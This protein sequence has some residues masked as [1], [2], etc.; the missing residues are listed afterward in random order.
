M[1]QKISRI[2]ALIVT[3]VLSVIAFFLRSHQLKT[4]FDEVGVIPGSGTWVLTVF[5][6]LAVVVF[7]AYA[8]ILRGR[9]KY[10]AV[11]SRELLPMGCSVA[12]ALALLLS[13]ILL[14]VSEEPERE[15]LVALGGLVTAVCWVAVALARYQGKKAHTVLFL[16]PAVFYV[17]DLICRFR[18]WTR[19]PVI[20]DY[21]FDLLAVI[22]TMCATFHLGG[23]CFDQGRRRLTVFYALSGV[24]FSAIAM[25]GASA[26]ELLGYL[27]AALWL[28]ANLWLLLR[29]GKARNTADGR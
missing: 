13:S 4:A 29:P 28:L 2:P 12:S 11:S 27:A 5:S 24:F 6:I 17:V 8:W 1:E 25:A 16:L 26:A 15:I 23:Y 18:L 7:A 22:C 21:C 10:G 19:D 9:K 14:L 20:L 3:A